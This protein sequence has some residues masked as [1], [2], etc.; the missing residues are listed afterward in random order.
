MLPTKDGGRENSGIDAVS[1]IPSVQQEAS[2]EQGSAPSASSQSAAMSK[3]EA[4]RKKNEAKHRQKAQAVATSQAETAVTIENEAST[5]SAK[6]YVPKL[7]VMKTAE[8]LRELS[9][10]TKLSL[11]TLLVKFSRKPEIQLVRR[12][13]P[14][15]SSEQEIMEAITDNDVVIL[16]GETGSGK[17]TRVPQFFMKLVMV[18]LI[19]QHVADA[20]PR[21]VA[22]ISTAKRVVAEELNVPFG[23]PKGHVGYQIRYDAEHVSEHTRIKFM[24]DG[25]LLKEIQQDFLLRPYSII[26]LD[27]AHERIVNTDI[28]IGL[29]SRIDPLRA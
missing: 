13:L 19:I 21:R 5:D 15:C 22:A 4:L 2:E 14:V 1:P 23:A 17:T 11:M 8:E 6:V 10:T 29:L 7:I 12:Q 25:I 28:L 26:L 16:C 3:L 18:I 24:T 27:E 9:K 20:L